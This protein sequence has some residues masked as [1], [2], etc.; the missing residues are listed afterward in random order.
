MS[1]KNNVVKYI[2]TSINII[3]DHGRIL[4]DN[5]QIKK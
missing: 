1:K 3:G 5:F 2:G 4:S